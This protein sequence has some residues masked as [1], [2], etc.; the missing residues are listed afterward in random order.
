M[1]DLILGAATG[2]E[3]SASRHWITVDGNDD[4]SVA[5]QRSDVIAIYPITPSSSTGK[6][7]DD[8][9]GVIVIRG[10]GAETVAATVEALGRRRRS[11]S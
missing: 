1:F 4:C 9:E 10:S 8:A 3:E 7:A 2:A 5:S 11:A 6:N